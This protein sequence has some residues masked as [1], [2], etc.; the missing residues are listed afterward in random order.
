[1]RV[2]GLVAGKKVRVEGE[3]RLVVWS[4]AAH[5]NCIGRIR[6]VVESRNGP[7]QL[8]NG[9]TF[10]NPE[11]AACATPQQQPTRMRKLLKVRLDMRRDMCAGM[12]AGMC[13][14]MRC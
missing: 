5:S 13:V 7:V 6:S 9:D 11:A 1:M 12:Y 2:R 4:D 3:L 14:D 10:Q 8:E